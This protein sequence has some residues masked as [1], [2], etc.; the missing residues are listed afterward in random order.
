MHDGLHRSPLD[1]HHLVVRV[2]PGEMDGN[3]LR[4]LVLHPFA[5]L[6][7]LLVGVVVSRDDKI[8]QLE[9]HPGFMD[10]LGAPEDVGQ[11]GS[12]DLHV[13]LVG[14]PLHVYVH[15]VGHRAQLLQGLL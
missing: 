9:M 2:E 5:E 4:E 15:G 8:G 6:R 10:Y 3:I 13:E 7:Y 14:E 12:A 11:M 1:V